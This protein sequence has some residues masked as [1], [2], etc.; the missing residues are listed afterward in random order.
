MYNDPDIS[1]RLIEHLKQVNDLERLVSKI[2]VGKIN[3]KEVIQL[4]RTL[5]QVEPIKDQLNDLSSKGLKRIA[6]QINPCNQL[7]NT[8]E[9][10]LQVRH[11]EAVSAGPDSVVEGL[12]GRV[13]DAAAH[14]RDGEHRRNRHRK[15]RRDL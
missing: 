3:P 12:A 7:L 11:G 5:N 9:K 14:V 13:V 2:A 6:D 10:T 4:K 1:E 8:I 15:P